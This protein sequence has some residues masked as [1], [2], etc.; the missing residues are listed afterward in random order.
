MKVYEQ[1]LQIREEKGA[2][3]LVLIDPDKQSMQEAIELA[4]VCSESGVDGLL[5][6]GSLM[7]TH[8]FDDLIKGIKAASPLPLIIFPG[9]TRQ[10]SP[11]ANAILYLSLISGRNAYYIIGD[12]VLAAP[13]IKS[14]NLEAISTAYMLIESGNITSAQ[15]LSD[16]R[17]IPREKPD[18]SVAHAMAAEL[19]GMRMI[20]LEAGSGAHLSVP[21]EHIAAICRYTSLPVIVG[22]GIR[23]PEEAARKVAAG[24][25]FIVT[26]NVIEKNRDRALISAF[27]DSIHTR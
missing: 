25:S 13:I 17:P 20:Y 16:T 14:M 21:E 4:R 11:Y 15:F 9:S 2:G 23:A 18:I 1:L 8:I 10:L 3:Y 19:L 12:Q 22:G 24:A 5:L 6:G 26:G 27:A 7:F